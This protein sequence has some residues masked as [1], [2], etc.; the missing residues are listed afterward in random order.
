MFKNDLDCPSG[1][2]SMENM[3]CSLLTEALIFLFLMFDKVAW[4]P[5][6]DSGGNFVQIVLA[7]HIFPNRPQ[8]QVIIY[9]SVAEFAAFHC[10]F[11]FLVDDM[12]SVLSCEGQS[13]VFFS[14]PLL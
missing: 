11:C 4:P 2:Y 9:D 7:A 8:T 14:K 12:N 1:L 13:R 10:C 5:E 3:A 6:Q